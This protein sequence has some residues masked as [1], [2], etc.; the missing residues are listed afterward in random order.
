MDNR[1]EFY[2]PAVQP[3]DPEAAN[4]EARGILKT[5]ILAAALSI[6]VLPGIILSVIGIRRSKA[7]AKAY[8]SYTAGVQ[9]G[10][11]FSIAALPLS[12]FSLLA[13]LLLIGYVLLWCWILLH[14]NSALPQPLSLGHLPEFIGALM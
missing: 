7:W 2:P 3:A 11:V 9:I 13:W 8:G 4:Q 12:I 14:T 10:R 1:N 6:L 5:G